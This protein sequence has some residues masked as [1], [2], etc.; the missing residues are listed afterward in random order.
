VNPPGNSLLV[1]TGHIQSQDVMTDKRTLVSP[2][3]EAIYLISNKKSC[4][5]L[6]AIRA[7]I[8]GGGVHMGTMTSRYTDAELAVAERELFISETAAE[9]RLPV[10]QASH[11]IGQTGPGSPKKAFDAKSI[12]FSDCSLR[13]VV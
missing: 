5:D 3:G 9:I 1:I 12:F 6:S 13:A 11:N 4:L 8:G 2:F 10:I 7:D